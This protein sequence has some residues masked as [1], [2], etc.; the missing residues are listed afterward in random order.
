[1]I[2]FC[3]FIKKLK[4]ISLKIQAVNTEFDLKDFLGISRFIY[5]E[6]AYYRRSN[7]DIVELFFQKKTIFKNHAKIQP[8]IVKS[9]DDVLGRF[10]LI[11][12]FKNPEICMLAFFE[13]LTHIRNRS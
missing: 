10:A 6:N 7:E 8:Y 13:A 3:P 4:H 2:D 9:G 5:R 11:N 1:M 12:D